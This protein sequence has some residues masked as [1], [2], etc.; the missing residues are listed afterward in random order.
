MS[1]KEK[2]TIAELE[3]L[4]NEPNKKINIMPDGSIVAV[5]GDE[6]A[7]DAYIKQQD[8]TIAALQAEV[9]RLNRQLEAWQRKSPFDTHIASYEVA[10][11]N[12]RARLESAE[13]ERDELRKV[14]WHLEYMVL[15]DSLLHGG[16]YWYL[17]KKKAEENNLDIAK[18][19]REMGK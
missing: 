1:E 4:L 13:K 8:A 15:Y 2:P 5:G 7:Y 12:L 9:E 11:A 10:I 17:S 3:A 18:L 16:S 19:Q 6:N 14:V